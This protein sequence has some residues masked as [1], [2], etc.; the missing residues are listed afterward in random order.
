MTVLAVSCHPDDM[1]FMMGGTL[2]LLKQ[3]GCSIHY[4]NVANGSDGSATLRPEQTAALRRTEAMRAA[5]VLGAVFHESLVEDLEVFYT[6]ELIRRVT[7]LVRQV[8]P[9][10]VLTMS[11]EDYM[12]DHMNTG[13]IA[14]TATFLRSVANYRSIPDEPAVFEDAML[15][16][17]TPH[18]LT[19]MM[20]RPIVP[21]NYVDVGSV[22]GEKE[23][24]LACHASQKEW[25]DKTQGFDSYLKTM[26][27]LTEKVGSMSGRFRFAEGWR[28]H[29]HVGF[30]RQDCNPLADILKDRCLTV[31][32]SGR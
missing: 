2:L 17:S 6:Q 26:C 24:A 9:D 8:K 5:E 28:R 11:L 10:I 14:V 18:I 7:A 12:E 21:E 22:M 25:L 16:H 31:A 30:T 1:E 32:A 13:R 23:R 4:I 27:D 15:Y 19:D 29:S 3:A 20:R